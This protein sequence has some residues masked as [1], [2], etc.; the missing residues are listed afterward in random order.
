[1]KVIDATAVLGNWHDASGVNAAFTDVTDLITIEGKFDPSEI[2]DPK[3]GKWV[4]DPA[5]KY[6]NE[7]A[8][9]LAYQQRV[10]H[11]GHVI[12]RTKSGYTVKLKGGEKQHYN[13]PDD[14]AEVAR[15]GK[16]LNVS[17]KPKVGE[18]G[19]AKVGDHVSWRSP[20]G[21]ALDGR[22]VSVD[23]PAALVDTPGGRKRVPLEKLTPYGAEK[24]KPEPNAGLVYDR[25]FAVETQQQL[26]KDYGG[27]TYG[28]QHDVEQGRVKPVSVPVNKLRLLQETFPGKV[29]EYAE[30]I[31]NGNDLGG[32]PTVV[33][34]G[35][36]YL[37]LDG[38]HRA[39][40]QVGAGATHLDVN[41]VEPGRRGAEKVS[42][43]AR[44]AADMNAGKPL[45]PEMMEAVRQWERGGQQPPA[46]MKVVEKAP[47][48]N[49]PLYKGIA[50]KGVGNK[51]AEAEVAQLAVAKP[52]DP[53][54]LD[55]ATSW[56]AQESVAR[57]FAGYE[58]DKQRGGQA[59]VMLK[60]DSGPAVN[61][62][63]Y[64][65][66]HQQDEWIKPGGA[67]T[68]VSNERHPTVRGLRLVTVREGVDS[69]PHPAD[70]VTTSA[71]PIAVAR[72]M[73][74]AEL[75]SAHTELARRAELLGKPGVKTR[76]HKAVT[77]E[78]VRRGTEKQPPFRKE[79]PK[80]EP[81][82]GGAVKLAW[83]SEG[84]SYHVAKTP[85]GNTAYTLHYTGGG[86]DVHPGGGAGSTRHLQPSIGHARTAKEAKTL[87]EQHSQGHAETKVE[88]TLKG[89]S[90]TSS[91]GKN[92]G[93]WMAS[94]LELAAM[95][96]WRAMGRTDGFKVT[97]RESHT[98]QQNLALY[99]R[100]PPEI[101]QYLAKQGA[102]IY[103]GE[104]GV[105]G[106]DNLKDIANH[107]P[108]GYGEGQTFRK[109][110]A[111]V[112][113]RAPPGSHIRRPVVAIGG[114]SS[115]YGTGSVNVSAHEVGHGT[116]FSSGQL[117][118]QPKFQEIY[119]QVTKTFGVN[120]YYLQGGPK[121]NLP[122]GS[123]AQ[124]FFAEAMA[125]WTE[126]R[127]KGRRGEVAREIMRA[128]GARA[129]THKAY[130]RSMMLRT[131]SPN[132]DS[133]NKALAEIE[134]LGAQLS[135]YFDDLHTTIA[136]GGTP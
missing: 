98:T 120:P 58:G 51:Q 96:E 8:K 83:Q 18:P 48:V 107:Q 101:R 102:E 36:L 10:S 75:T 6:L 50:D 123:G 88:D 108:S 121:G 136:K 116:D 35:D 57:D 29:S 82:P 71:D 99:G 45:S 134:A 63:K 70:R 67:Y 131:G 61:V 32:K 64:T 126:N 2:R 84:S 104:G 40:A 127:Y 9:S 60:V 15:T 42:D 103:I 62:G 19:T 47:A 100:I 49:K 133:M 114:G 21:F 44:I 23:G 17:F 132:N 72:T 92:T 59:G 31:K 65:S 125:A 122:S 90:P 1:M 79:A 128:L 3:T 13:S 55:R 117:S 129:G 94:P 30:K 54:V 95:K 112:S 130:K 80:P 4:R 87:A 7:A 106:L 27:D 113:F 110:A 78:I 66:L 46:L 26:N 52:G 76:A 34:S 74:D 39:V 119:K 109:V 33:K 135:Q 24:I 20:S 43:P 89:L 12:D 5:G 86:W 37:L 111:V 11:N 56:S 38:N 69:K 91:P 81:K 124:E 41:L 22:V 93:A 115:T 16:H 53:V 77:D 105:S 14:A 85:D 28:W 97:N 118:Q 73:S 25:R 68:V